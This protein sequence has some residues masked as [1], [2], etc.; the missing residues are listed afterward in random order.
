[1]LLA[2]VLALAG[3]AVGFSVQGPLF[4]LLGLAPDVR[5]AA[6]DY[7]LP[8]LYGLP[9]I[10]AWY[11]VEAVFR[12]SGDTRTPMIVLGATLLRNPP[13]GWVPPGYKPPTQTATPPAPTTR[14]V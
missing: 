11:L 12:G 7:L 14:A 4:V 1:M 5:T 3:A 6:S 8:I 2:L 9:V 13:D 10:G